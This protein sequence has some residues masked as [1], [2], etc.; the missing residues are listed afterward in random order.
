M[1]NKNS[2][3]R[4]ILSLIFFHTM[5]IVYLYQHGMFFNIRPLENY[6]QILDT[7]WLKENLFTSLVFLHSQPPLFNLVLGLAINLNGDNVKIGLMIL[8]QILAISSILL[9]FINLRNLRVLDS[10]RNCDTLKVR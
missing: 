5:V 3:I 9:L 7:D 1:K 4:L 10:S 8:Y 2:D 6:I